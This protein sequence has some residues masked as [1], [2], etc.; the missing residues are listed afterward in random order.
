MRRARTTAA[1]KKA[2]TEEEKAIL[3]RSAR[4]LEAK[5]GHT[6]RSRDLGRI[7]V[8]GR[9]AHA[10]KSQAARLGL[11]QPTRTA[12]RWTDRERQVLTVLA[13]TRGLGARSIKERGF[14]SDQGTDVQSF[15]ERSTDAIAQMKRRLHLVDDSRSR[16]A[17][18]A[19]RLTTEERRRLRAELRAN[20]RGLT[21]EDFAEEFGVSPSTIRRYRKRWRIRQTWRDAMDL[22]RAC[23]RRQLLSSLVRE[24]N[25]IRWRKRKQKLRD[26]LLRRARRLGSAAAR[27]GRKLELR[28]CERCGEAWPATKEF[29]AP[30]KKRRNGGVV[31]VYLRRTCRVCPRRANASEE[32]ISHTSSASTR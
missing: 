32:E 15:R 4:E 24:R 21:T 22:P 28:I 11:T 30:S 5:L 7:R 8:P 31:A 19:K 26:E 14:F 3:V 16:R 18:Y 20:P 29:F 9:T 23:E 6:L 13:R 12:R 2:W 17:R 10:V 27:R 1:S 25:L